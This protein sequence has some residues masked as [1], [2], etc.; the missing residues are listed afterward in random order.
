MAFNRVAVRLNLPVYWIGDADKDGAI[1]PGEVAV[2]PLL[3]DR[4][5]TATRGSTAAR[6]T[7]AFEAAVRAHRRRG[8]E[9]AERPDAEEIARRK[10][11]APTSIR[12]A[13]TLVRSDLTEL[14]AD[15]KAFVQPHA[16][17]RADSI[18]ELYATQI[19]AAALGLAGPGR[20]PREPEPLPPRLGARVRRRRRPRRTPRA[21]RSPARRSRS[22]TPIRR[23]CRRSASFCEA[24]EKLPEREGA[25]RPVHRRARRRGGQA[26]AG[27]V[28]RGVQGADARRSPTEL[29]A[30]AD[31]D[32]G[33]G[34]GGR[35]RRT[36]TRRRRASRRTTGARRRGV[37][38]R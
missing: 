30:A 26:R 34:R 24:L 15:D 8:K 25:A 14:S 22:A 27:A 7:P 13:P 35:S 37:G 9:R 5:A 17:G 3:S 36:S 12:G 32:D 4:R 19:G 21:R 29:R 28:H 11:V 23:R 31:G 38:A 2:A 1:D 33:P 18:D 6:F 20:R 10:L 16:R